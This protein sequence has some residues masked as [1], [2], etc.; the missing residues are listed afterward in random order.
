MVGEKTCHRTRSIRM[1]AS[2]GRRRAGDMHPAIS[3][4]RLT[5]RTSMKARQ[6]VQ[7][8]LQTYHEI[9]ITRECHCLIAHHLRLHYLSPSVIAMHP[10]GLAAKIF[11]WSW[12]W[13][14]GETNK[15]LHLS[16][17]P[18]SHRTSAVIYPD[19]THISSSAAISISVP[20][21]RPSATMYSIHRISCLTP[22][23][24]VGN[25]TVREDCY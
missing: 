10:Y 9:H 22:K 23:G 7:R 21:R 24:L 19:S 6:D 1:Q 13:G 14:L 2:F 15:R 8:L 18:S 11:I 3:V 17:R 12:R 20:S 4:F 5:R 16:F 25:T